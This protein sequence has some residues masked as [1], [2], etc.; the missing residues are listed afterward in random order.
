VDRGFLKNTWAPATG[1]PLSSFTT[2]VTVALA[3]A[4]INGME[5]IGRATKVDIRQH[6]GTSKKIYYME[7]FFICIY[8]LVAC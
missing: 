8:F 2:P 5:R 1:W 4:A 6:I 3:M 7:T